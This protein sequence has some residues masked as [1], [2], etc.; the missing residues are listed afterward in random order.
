[1]I[2]WTTYGSWLQ[3]DNRGYVRDGEILGK[4]ETLQKAN[5]K[6]LKSNVVELAR[7]ERQIVRDAILNKAESLGQKLHSLVV[8]SSHVHIVAEH[9]S[10]SIEMVVS[11]YK[12]A[13]RL[14]LRANGFIG[15]V[16]TRRFDKRFCFNREQLKIKIKY[17]QA[18]RE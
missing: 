8:C 6:K 13:A 11:H 14:A 2:T 4:N 16:W 18:H 5:I 15:R 10:E 1:M 17:V 7:Q 9:I 3:G 12:N